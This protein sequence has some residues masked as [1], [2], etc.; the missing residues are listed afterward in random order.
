MAGKRGFT[1]IELLVVVAIIAVLVAILLPALTKAREG[2]KRA[3]C[4]SNQK[5]IATGLV[6][7]ALENYGRFP[8]APY[9]A[10][11]SLSY[12][13]YVGKDTLPG[14]GTSGSWFGLGLLFASKIITDPK[15][16]Y[17][18]S[19]DGGQFPLFT[20]PAGWTTWYHE[21]YLR[22]CIGYLYRLFGESGR[23]ADDIPTE[24]ME[25]L[26]KLTISSAPPRFGLS[27]D[28]FSYAWPHVNPYGLNLAFADGHAEFMDVGFEEYRRA[29]HYM[30]ADT[31]LIRDPFTF[32]FWKALD[33]RDFS[34]LQDNWPLP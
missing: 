32:E 13:V 9:W 16:F 33:K 19:M 29:V 28:I 8:P 24:E 3:V 7:Y 6:E 10:N 4:L 26:Q 11:A 22:R 12:Q 30:S 18:P 5:Q 34:E 25:K 1:L 20:Y 15:A 27:V 17:C 2:A 21:G 31:T 14:V 23:T